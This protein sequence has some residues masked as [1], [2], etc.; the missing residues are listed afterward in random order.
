MKK[1][2]I[3]LLILV[4]CLNFAACKAEKASEDKTEPV[5]KITETKDNTSKPTLPQNN[6][7][8]LAYEG[9]VTGL[10]IGIGSKLQ[11]A[12]A[13]FGEPVALDNFEGTSYISY[14]VLD[15]ILDR[16]VE[17]TKSEAYI[18]GVIVSEGYELYG[19]KVGMS[20]AQIKAE[21]GTPT[22]EL[23][24]TDDEGEIWK[25]EYDCGEYLLSFYSDNKEA[26]TVSAYLSKKQ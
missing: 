18:S 22:Q 16:I 8:Q 9:K 7:L 24:E 19:V 20:P 25:M 4:L 12:I 10:S 13:Q 3:I 6:A 5:S 26:A 14:E 17:D 2:V 21:L 11:D 15:I 23:L 1:A